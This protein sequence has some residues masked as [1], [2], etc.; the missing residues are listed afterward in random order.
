MEHWW[1]LLGR[2]MINIWGHYFGP[3]QVVHLDKTTENGCLAY[4]Y[5]VDNYAVNKNRDEKEVGL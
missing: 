1:N 4:C 5:K 2:L 3:E